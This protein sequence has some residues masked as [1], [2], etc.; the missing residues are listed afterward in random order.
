MQMDESN[1]QEQN[2]SSPSEFRV[3]GG[4]SKG[5]RS[6]SKNSAQV[7]ARVLSSYDIRRSHSHI[8]TEFAGLAGGRANYESRDLS[9]MMTYLGIIDLSQHKQG[10]PRQFYVS[11]NL[12]RPDR[13]LTLRIFSIQKYAVG[14]VTDDNM[15]TLFSVG[16]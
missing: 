6:K 11:E 10:V 4:L 2:V 3:C 8:S 9:R 14:V 7:A 16:T 15:I 1:E 5:A 13:Q 12:E